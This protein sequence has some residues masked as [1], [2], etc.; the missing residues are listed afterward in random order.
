[1]T[2]KHPP[3]RPK[4]PAALRL[5]GL[6]LLAA[7]VALLAC[8]APPARAEGDILADHLEAKGQENTPWQIKA[9]NLAAQ[10]DT[11]VLQA[12]GNVVLTQGE[13]TLK[14]DHATYYRATGWV[15]LVGNVDIDW[16][17]DR[18]RAEEAEFDL[19]NK[20]GWLKNGE[21]FVSEPHLYFRGERI[22]KHAG[23]RY[24]FRNARVTACDE[25]GEAWSI[26]MEEGEITLE[27]Y[28][29]MW[30]PRLLV[31][32][33]PAFY[34]PVGILPVKSKRQSG[35]LMPE[36]GTSSRN[37]FMYNQP[38]YWAI[39][40]EADATFYENWMSERG[41]MQGL[42]FRHTPNTGT[43]GL[44]RIDYLHDAIRESTQ[45]QE[46]SQFHNDGLTRPNADRYWIRSKLDTHLLDPHWKAKLDIDWVSDQNFL[47]EF[48]AGKTGFTQNRL[49]FLEEFSRDIANADA[50]ERESA[51]LVSRSW[52]AGGVA[53]KTAWTQ[54]LAYQNGNRSK[55]RN[56]TAQTL[57]ELHAYLWK[58]RLF[59]GPL[60]FEA[61]AGGTHFWR[62]YGT[63]GT[64]L[65]LL[66]KASLPVQ[67]GP[68]SVIPTL[69][70][71]T[72]AYFVSRY[73]DHPAPS[74]DD[75][76][77]TRSLPTMNVSAFTEYYKVFDLA[78]SSGAPA[79]NTGQPLLDD[80]GRPVEDPGRWT[81]I[82]HAVQPRVDYDWTPHVSQSNKPFFDELDRLAAQNEIT[83]SLTNLF[84][85]KRERQV[86]R[87]DPDAPLGEDGKP[88][89]VPV[90]KADYREFLRLR[91]EQ[92]F[93]LREATRTEQRDQYPR[94][95]FSDLMGE[96]IVSPEEW[97]SLVNRSYWSPYSADITRHEHFLRGLW[98]NV[99]RAEF[100]LDFQDAADTYKD[101]N[102]AR[103]RQ[104]R[105]GVDLIAS[106][107]WSTGFTYRADLTTNSDL[108]QTYYVTYTH[109][110]WDVTVYYTHTPFEDRFEARVQLM[111]LS[112]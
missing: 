24:T 91:L 64:R 54:N 59:S 63:Q 107:R 27:G 67:A 44:W 86:L 15:R 60:E 83:Y 37:G 101:R 3:R 20:V 89:G 16:S 50:L 13:N 25:P 42:E 81:K 32:D 5:A 38:I 41:L 62:R 77:T 95:P 53:V 49:E 8:P 73:E 65:D 90:L 21:I 23:D 70:L 22:E 56:P 82:R 102:R 112:F 110:C 55:D 18:L 94:R 75:S 46:D 84:D 35:L 87:V 57:P 52:D 28:A 69:G 92:S 76:A 36:W 74:H 68:L 58:D 34:A 39:S 78:P 43:K 9:D 103:I 111:G 11:E 105:F 10:H 26:A 99:A 61:E 79:L 31:R 48:K 72:T 80:K 1:M 40:D 106:R 71:R 51:L 88:L 19:K 109:Q 30:H 6:A 98:K 100:G 45:A 4:H 47:R 108:E 14:A 66:P 29:W 96:L 93:D 33:Q 2:P 104:I 97:L 17:T 7:L 12:D 85:R